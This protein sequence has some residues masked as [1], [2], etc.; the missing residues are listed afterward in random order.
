[1]AG[2]RRR[3]VA[4]FSTACRGPGPARRTRPHHWHLRAHP[5]TLASALPVRWNRP[6]GTGTAN[7]CRP[8]SHRL[9]SVGFVEWLALT[10]PRPSLATSAPSDTRRGATCGS[11]REPSYWTLRDIVQA[12]DS[13]LVTLALEGPAAYRDRF[14]L[15]HR[16]RAERPNQIWQA[17]HTELDILIIGPPERPD[18]PWLTTLMDDHSPCCPRTPDR[19][20]PGHPRLSSSSRQACSAVRQ[21]STSMRQRSWT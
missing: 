7:R 14:E 9:R 3:A 12:L 18:R 5:A 8:A 10:R 19:D 1:M 21:A 4:G 20:S 16:F 2:G 6:T 17:D 11:Y 15:V 13:A